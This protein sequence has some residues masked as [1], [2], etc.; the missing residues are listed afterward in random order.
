MD[1]LS[2]IAGEPLDTA[3]TTPLYK[4]LKHRILQVVAIGA[5]GAGEALPTEEALCERL[6]LSRATVRRCFKDLVD[7]GYVTRCR[8]RGT[9]VADPGE[10]GGL[11]TLYTQVSTSSTIE[12][13]G[14]RAESRLIRVRELPADA[15]IAKRLHIRRG[16][17][18][19]EVNRQRLADGEPIMHEVAYV[20]RSLCPGLGQ[21]DFDRSIYEY[22]A[23]ASG[24]FAARTDEVIEAVALDRQEARLIGAGAG[25]AAL[26][27]VATSYD[28]QDEPIETSV[29]IARADR[30]RVLAHYSSEGARLRKEIG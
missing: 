22:I 19:W 23:E 11:D 30:M 3:S 15:G 25:M 6:G 17:R 24:K 10:A 8:G 12:R 26:R 28:S 5:I 1:A 9:F 2:A 7:E 20:P 13:S 27:I 14:A 4:Q 16:T 29:G 18:V 21:M